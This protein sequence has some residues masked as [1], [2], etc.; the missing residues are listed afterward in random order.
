MRCTDSVSTPS[1]IILL[2]CPCVANPGVIEV[3]CRVL[4]LLQAGPVTSSTQWPPPSKLLVHLPQ[5]CLWESSHLSKPRVSSL[6]CPCRRLLLHPAA[7]EDESDGAD[8]WEAMDLDSV[9]KLGKAAEEEVKRKV[10][11]RIELDVPDVRVPLA[12]VV[13]EC[14]LHSR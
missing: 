1:P 10:D 12:S 3:C 9:P 5:G 13:F 6:S 2:P 11:W 7:E 14:C 4:S 8:D